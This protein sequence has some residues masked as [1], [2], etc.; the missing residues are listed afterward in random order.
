MKFDQIAHLSFYWPSPL[1]IDVILG[2]LSLS[3][4]NF[5]S[6]NPLNLQASMVAYNFFHQKRNKQSR[7]L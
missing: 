4:I 2:T 6:F 3:T 7:Y 1:T 5:L